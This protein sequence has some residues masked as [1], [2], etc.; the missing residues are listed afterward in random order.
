MPAMPGPIGQYR[1]DSELG[2]GSAANVYRA[3]DTAQNRVVAV[4]IIRDLATIQ[5]QKRF[6]RE[7]RTMASIR[8]PN[9]AAV[10]DMG[11]YMQRTY[12]VMELVDGRPLDLRQPQRDV[13]GRLAKIAL[14]L[15]EV[16][17][18][19]VIHRDIKP[20]N[21]LVDARGE[22]KLVDFGVAHL[23]EPGVGE[24]LT[25][26]GQ[27]IGT[28]AYMAPEQV[29]G[30][31]HLIGPGT[32]VYAIGAMLYEMLAGH[33]PYADKSGREAMEHLKKGELAPPPGP[34]ALVGLCMKA[35]H[36]DLS[37]RHPRAGALAA[38]LR[39]YL[40]SK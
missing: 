14:A 31:R 3:T 27:V 6:V 32:D 39:R 20:S 15:D 10:F 7:G 23:L 40:D 9:I 18:A 16:H 30:R 17:R 1:L 25:T 29:F 35:M 38:D 4:K 37:R 33:R 21:I 12:I 28:P 11:E 34:P 2:R 19:G 36:R 8:H 13:I 5:T 26:T 22:P 24:E